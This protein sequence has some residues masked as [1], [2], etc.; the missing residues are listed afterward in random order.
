MLRLQ[1]GYIVLPLIALIGDIY[2]VCMSF[3]LPLML[4]I[5]STEDFN[6]KHCISDA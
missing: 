5:N 4:C 6:A 1:E 2:T 3:G